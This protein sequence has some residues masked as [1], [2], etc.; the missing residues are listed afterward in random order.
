[1]AAPI[2]AGAAALLLE[3]DPT[4]THTQ[5]RQ[6]LQTGARK[7][8]TAVVP[9]AE[10]RSGAGILD[11]VSSLEA[12]AALQTTARGAPKA[13]QSHLLLAADLL[14]PSS[15]S[16][17]QGLLQLRDE[18]GHVAANIDEDRLS[19]QVDGARLSRRLRAQTAGLY[20]FELAGLVDSGGSQATV[21]VSFD[22]RPFLATTIAI[23]VD[24][25]AQLEGQTVSGGC[26]I[27][28][29]SGAPSERSHWP[30]AVLGV[31]VAA[32]QRRRRTMIAV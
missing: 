2:V 4:L 25:S 17:V 24:S 26:G 12:L 15:D 19:V 31:L 18:E 32:L 28:L 7:L 29:A 11:A 8:S 20:D 30:L 22:D 16:R 1:M 13:S 14:R 10:L 23:A 27:A 3:R 9:Q 21:T 6:L 5:V